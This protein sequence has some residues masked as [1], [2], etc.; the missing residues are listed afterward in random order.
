MAT[1]KQPVPSPVTLG[2][3]GPSVLAQISIYGKFS[4]IIGCP[5]LLR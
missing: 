5:F 4:A 2:G 3:L 1:P